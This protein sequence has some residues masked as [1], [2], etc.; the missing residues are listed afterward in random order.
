MLSID[1]FLNTNIHLSNYNVYNNFVVIE[2]YLLLLLTCTLLQVQKLCIN[3]KNI[4][5]QVFK[6]GFKF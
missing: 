1:L 2:K 6:G 3:K 4:F 5:L